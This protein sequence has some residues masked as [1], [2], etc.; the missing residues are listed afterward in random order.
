MFSLYTAISIHRGDIQNMKTETLNKIV[1]SLLALF[2]SAI[3]LAMIKPFL[4]AIF[5][6]AIFSAITAPL[7]RRF[8]RCLGGRRVLASITTLVLIGAGILLPLA[9]LIGI[10]T[11]QAVGVGQSIKP[12]IEKQLS[13][14]AGISGYLGSIPFFDYLKAYEEPL[15]QKAGELVGSISNFLING[16]SSA[17][18]GTVNFLFMGFIFLYTMFFFLMEGDKLLARILYYLPLK[19]QDESRLLEKF[20]SVTRATLKGTAIIGA[21]QGGLAGLAFA[22]VGIDSAVFWGTIMTVLSIIPAVGSG[23][24]WFPA[25]IILFAGGNHV[26]AVGLLL[27][28]GLL[29]GSLDNFLRPRMVGRDI[30]M[31]D[32][33]ILFGTLG[34]ISLFGIIGFIIG[35][36]VAALFVTVW[37]IYG[38]AFRDVLPEVKALRVDPRQA[39]TTKQIPEV[40]NT[41]DKKSSQN[42]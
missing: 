16:L 40:D 1:L 20:T 18:F 19:D 25:V 23:L 11:A 35:P 17:A 5:L 14:P 29:V 33:M 2:I 39:K 6:A 36:I 9:G 21:I 24:I 12:W 38:E 30:K 37:E 4:M 32:L 15:L 28:C 42:P 8:E 10:V 41:A 26:Q 22:V 13:E 27:F 7:Y 34:G 3:F 31:H